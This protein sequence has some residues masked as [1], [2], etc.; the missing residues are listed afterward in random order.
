MSLGQG[1]EPVKTTIGQMLIS[2]KYQIP[3]FQREFTWGKSDFQ[4]LAEDILQ[5][6]K[7]SATLFLG[8]F[9]FIGLQGDD[10]VKITDGQQRLTS[11]FIFLACLRDRLYEIGKDNYGDA[12]QERFLCQRDNEN[13]LQATLETNATYEYVDY[14]LVNKNPYYDDENFGENNDEIQKFKIAQEVF[15][16]VLEHN[17]DQ[18]DE[19]Y[20][21][22]LLSVRE[23]I[24]KAFA[25]NLFSADKKEAYLAFESLNSKGQ[26]L[27]DLD[28]IKNR[29]IYT[30]ETQNFIAKFVDMWKKV[31]EKNADLKQ[32][33]F[34]EYQPHGSI[35]Q[36]LMISVLK[37]NNI[38][39]DDFLYLENYQLYKSFKN[40]F[41]NISEG[42]DSTYL[43]IINQ[44]K[45]YSEAL[46]EIYFPN[47]NNWHS[48]TGKRIYRDFGFLSLLL[49]S[50][51]INDVSLLDMLT[52]LFMVAYH[53]HKT[54]HYFTST[55]LLEIT[56]FILGSCILFGVVSQVSQ[57]IIGQRRKQVLFRQSLKNILHEL[58]LASSKAESYA[59]VSNLKALMFLFYRANK[60]NNLYTNIHF[61]KKT[62]NDKIKIYENITTKYIL[63]CVF[64]FENNVSLVDSGMSVEHIVPESTQKQY[65]NNLGNLTLLEDSINSG[66]ADTPVS[67]KIENY[68]SQSRNKDV[69][70]SVIPHFQNI[71][72]QEEK[73]KIDERTRFLESKFFEYSENLFKI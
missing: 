50:D 12:I 43:K 72:H 33:I 38:L 58:N 21:K 2:R 73:I 71:I 8:T 51:Y 24:T 67:D 52:E 19:E 61:T 27:S 39:D 20:F 59:S 45:V 10:V 23:T 57:L 47:I 60:N 68:Y 63:E 37:S 11:I 56:D 31:R 30:A 65:T 28:L 55:L 29:I 15:K 69:L 35:D 70:Q 40:Y 62:G 42:I 36:W 5:N 54:T 66:A 48:Q 18:N 64:L 49:N 26:P 22:W 53:K 13:A 3:D 44:F 34:V 1:F 16:K 17:S 46:H 7:K 25:I 6:E 32:K 41:T 4:T 14:I 9:M